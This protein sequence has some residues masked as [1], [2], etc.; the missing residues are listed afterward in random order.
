MER[1]L[2]A[3]ALLVL[4]VAGS[5]G[6]AEEPG[7]RDSV[8]LERL[9][10]F[11]KPGGGYTIAPPG[12][13][14]VRLKDDS[15]LLLIPQHGRQALAVQAGSTRHQS[16]VGEPIALTL[17]EKE[18]LFYLLLLLPEGKGWAAVGAFSP[19]QLRASVPATLPLELVHQALVRKRASLPPP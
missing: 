4:A 9:V 12:L 3:I 18:S 14:L 8:T 1:A 7:E 6:R 5:W 15:Q 19:V 16:E 17:P 10:Y 11:F 2:P 13:Y